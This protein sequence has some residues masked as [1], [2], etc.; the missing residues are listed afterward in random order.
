MSNRGVEVSIPKQWIDQQ[1]VCFFFA[2]PD[3]QAHIRSPFG[4]EMKGEFWAIG[5]HDRNRRRVL[6]WWVP[7]DNPYYST[8]RSFLKIP[9][10][11]FSDETVE[12]RD[13]VLLPILHAVMSTAKEGLPR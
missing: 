3:R 11:L 2:H 6:L 4:D 5:D 10:L 8:D 12:D 7:Q 9:F 1:D 13:D